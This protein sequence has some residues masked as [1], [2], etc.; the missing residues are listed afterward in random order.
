VVPTGNL[1]SGLSTSDYFEV[2]GGGELHAGIRF[3]RYY[4]ARIFFELYSLR[5]GTEL[6]TAPDAVSTYSNDMQDDF[7]ITSTVS[8]RSFGLSLMAGSPRG[9]L[10]GYGELGFALVHEYSWNRDFTFDVHPSCT[11][12]ESYGGPGLRIGGGLQWPLHEHIQLTASGAVTVGSFTKH[13][14]S[15]NC[16]L[17]DFEGEDRNIKDTSTHQQLF[18]GVGADFL[19]GG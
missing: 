13:V 5:P 6:D 7:E 15:N 17:P 10:G 16:D 4:G 1:E 11:M 14:M 3:L 9:Q 18:L 19:M 12:T 2:G 8:A